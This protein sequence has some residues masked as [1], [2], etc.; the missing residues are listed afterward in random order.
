MKRKIAEDLT[1]RKLA[2]I[3][4]INAN[5]NYDQKEV[6]KKQIL[7]DMEHKFNQAL[8]M[9]YEPEEISKRVEEDPFLAAAKRGLE[10]TDQHVK[11]GQEDVGDGEF[12]SSDV[13]QDPLL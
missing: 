12:T 4:A 6:N 13:D 3:T 5:P 2:H 9:L 7:E 10:W 11:K 1:W 8:E